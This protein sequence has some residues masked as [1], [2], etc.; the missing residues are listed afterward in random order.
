MTREHS[1]RKA[2][3]PR[4]RQSTKWLSLFW[5]TPTTDKQ[6]VWPPFWP[7]DP[8]ESMFARRDATTNFARWRCD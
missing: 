5:L 4:V 2:R 8:T 6:P 7:T 1:I 3:S